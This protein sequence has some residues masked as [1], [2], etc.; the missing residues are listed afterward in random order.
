MSAPSAQYAAGA[1]MSSDETLG[2]LAR[3]QWGVF[4]REQAIEAGL[5]KSSIHARLSSGEWIRVQRRV[6]RFRG[7]PDSWRQQV[8]AATLSL[9]DGAMASHATAAFLWGLDVGLT[10]PK[11]LDFIVPLDC[12]STLLDA[13][14][15]RTRDTP[16]K[17]SLRHKIPV[18]SVARTLMDLAEVLEEPA[19]ELALG[20]A[21]KKYRHAFASTEKLIKKHGHGRHHVDVL[22][23]L[24][25][26]RRGKHPESGLEIL[27]RLALAADGLPKFEEQYPIRDQHGVFL[28]RGDIVWPQLGIVLFADS[29]EWHS[30]P[31]SFEND[32]RQWAE[33]SALGWH[34]MH[35]TRKMLNTDAWLSRLERKIAQ[36]QLE[37]AERIAH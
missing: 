26:A 33:L 35:V 22:S 30:D 32:R 34:P 11:N 28:V 6:Y 31:A 25:E 19:L 3:Q 9:G 12:F 29:R 8:R 21:L 20:S 1:V 24:L 27:T 4:S 16:K 14:V 23:R 18:T 36:R 7:V 13:R 2:D 17:P 15:H 10:P 37:L 5:N